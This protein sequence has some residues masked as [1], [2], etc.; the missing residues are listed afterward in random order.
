MNKQRKINT[1]RMVQN[2]RREHNLF[3]TEAITD[4]IICIVARQNHLNF[5]SVTLYFLLFVN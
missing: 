1:I 4:A 3:V 5:F 2:Q